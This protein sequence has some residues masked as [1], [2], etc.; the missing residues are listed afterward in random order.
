MVQGKNVYLFVFALYITFIRHCCVA[1][2][3]LS[4]LRFMRWIK[5]ASLLSS[6]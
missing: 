4:G 1:H 3:P 5:L 2:C 6:G